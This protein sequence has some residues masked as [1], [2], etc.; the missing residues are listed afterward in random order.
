[1]YTLVV[2]V[3]VLAVM[4]KAAAILRVVE[5]EITVGMAVLLVEPQVSMVGLAEVA[6]QIVELLEVA[7]MVLE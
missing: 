7:I 2:V 1:M 6:H 3:A 5:V 4:Q